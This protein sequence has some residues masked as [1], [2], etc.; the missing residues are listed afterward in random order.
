MTQKLQFLLL[1]FLSTV[2][3]VMA[4][5]PVWWG[6]WNNGMPLQPTVSLGDGS[7]HVALRITANE[8][9]LLSGST[10]HGVR[11]YL[12]DKTAVSQAWVWVSAA[13]FAGT[14]PQPDKFLKE[15]PLEALK[16]VAHDAQPTELLL[17]EPTA[18]MAAG[19]YANA[20]VGFTLRLEG[21][22]Q[23]PCLLL[24]AGS[25]TRVSGNSFYIGWG[26]K[27]SSYGPLALQLLVSGDKIPAQ[28]LSVQPLTEPLLQAGQDYD[29]QVRLQTEGY[30]AVTDYDLQVSFADEVLARQHVSLEQPVGELGMTISQPL[31]LTLPATAR[32]ADWKVEVTAVN[33]Q[34]NL[35]STPQAAAPMVLLSQLPLRRTV[36]EELTGTWCP[37][38]P[39]GMVGLRLLDELFGDRFIGIAEHGGDASEPMR[40]PEYDTSSFIRGVSSRMGGRPSCS[41][42]RTIDCD[43]Y[44]GVGNVYQ[45]GAD[46]VV[47]YQLQQPTMADLN[48]SATWA[49]DAR[50]TISYDVSTTFRYS[51]DEAPF[52][53]MLVLTADSLTG[54]DSNWLQANTLV[55]RTEYEDNLDEFVYGERHMKLFYNHVPVFVSGV[56]Q[57]IAGSITAPL[58]CDEAQ[59]Y[60]SI[61][62]IS[63]NHLI[64]SKDHL[65]AIAMLLDTRT[66]QVV[67]AAGSNIAPYNAAGVSFVSSPAAAT[68]AWFSLDGRRLSSRPLR[69]VFIEQTVDGQGTVRS[70]LRKK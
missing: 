35:G 24:S 7:T 34:P 28:G 31:H 2:T 57:G 40:L 29:V 37:N 8:N 26:Q 41:V 22:S 45:F 13:Q 15:I 23:S 62:D 55:G 53:L 58:V 60:F 61:V 54:D 65:H 43:P 1:F 10:L 59:H 52:A 50:T 70:T 21:S 33:G 46:Q 49:D 9:P 47:S 42:D 67:N 14:V 64:Q 36:M 6:Y 68:A 17:D 48:V 27:E 39:R 20:Y 18:L 19:R 51:A 16:D 5:T 66:G 63:N 56:E 11:F 44:G 4:Q 38:C 3:P 32:Q 25:A 69:G 30:R 12:S